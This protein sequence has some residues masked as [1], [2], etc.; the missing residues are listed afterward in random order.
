MEIR[1]ICR[2]E[3]RGSLLLWVTRDHHSDGW[4][5]LERFA[6]PRW[7]TSTDLIENGCFLLQ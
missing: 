5:G 4:P 1:G 2:E 7:D 6:K 3:F